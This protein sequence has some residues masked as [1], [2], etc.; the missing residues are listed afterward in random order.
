M[1]TKH[2]N[3]INQ[4]ILIVPLLLLGF[5][6]NIN[7]ARVSQWSDEIVLKDSIYALPV[8]RLETAADRPFALNAH[9]DKARAALIIET[10]G[11]P[12]QSAVL[13]TVYNASGKMV[14]DLS[15]LVQPGSSRL[16][17]NA[18]TIS[19]GIFIVRLK[20]GLGTRTAKLLLTR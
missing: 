15:S 17:M 20:T 9:V 2:H 8:R 16:T 12:Y 10:Q 3:S 1:I 6:S 4:G 5:A 11:I 19:P 13:L 7:A 18:H 14:A